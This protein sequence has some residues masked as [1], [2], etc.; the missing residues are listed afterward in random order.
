MKSNKNV[1]SVPGPGANLVNFTNLS[2]TVRRGYYYESAQD[3]EMETRDLT[4]P[5]ATRIPPVH[6]KDLTI[7]SCKLLIPPP[8]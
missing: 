3:I 1:V 8:T 4:V 5:G 7:S 2:S 6:I